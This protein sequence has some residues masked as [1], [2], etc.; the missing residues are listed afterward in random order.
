MPFYQALKSKSKKNKRTIS[1]LLQLRKHL[2]NEIPRK[3]E[4][5]LLLCTWNIRD[6]DKPNHGIRELEAL[7]YLAEIISHFDIVAIQEVYRDLTALKKVMN[8]LGG[9]WDFICSDT[10]E[11]ARGNNER[12]AYVFDKRKVKFG[13]LA[14]ELV[15]P[16]MRRKVNGKMTTKLVGQ[17]WRTPMLCGFQ[18]AWA[19]FI[20]CSVHIQWGES[21][22]N[23]KSRKDEIDHIAKFLKKR[24]EDPTSWA[25]KIILLGDFNIFNKKDLTYKALE[26]QEF[27]Y[28]KALENV[29]TKGSGTN[30]KNNRHYDHILFRQRPG[31]IEATDG[32]V[33][34]PFQ[35]VYTAQ[36]EAEYKE[37]M[38]KPKKKRSDPDKYY[39]YKTWRTHQISDHKPLWVEFKIDY[40]DEYLEKLLSD[41]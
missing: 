25:R 11:G 33:V 37:L 26:K 41:Q 3:K 15:I 39:R 34:D 40:T 35:V 38:L 21:T 2:K 9:D 7:H 32:G 14:G 17:S 4:D 23:S 30:A 27:T 8:I 29:Y 16:P 10:T 28:P 31:G 6:F 18:S 36:E 5:S 22:A 1:K 13:G 20:L 24:T 12:M 19:K